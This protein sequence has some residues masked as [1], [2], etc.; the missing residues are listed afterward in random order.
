MRLTLADRR[1]AVLNADVRARDL[2]EEY[3]WLEGKDG[4]IPFYIFVDLIL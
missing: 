2:I 3:P 4:V 1:A